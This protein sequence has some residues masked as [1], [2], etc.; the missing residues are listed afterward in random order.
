MVG[1]KIKKA[2]AEGASIPLRTR[3]SRYHS[4]MAGGKGFEGQGALRN[5]RTP[6]AGLS[7]GFAGILEQGIRRSISQRSE[8]FL[9]QKV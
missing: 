3:A 5:I 6:E 1:K 2:E 8:V 9:G 4:V 7:P